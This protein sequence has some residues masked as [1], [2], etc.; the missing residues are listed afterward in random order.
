MNEHILEATIS[1]DYSGQRLDATLA[2]LFP[3]FS[4]TFLQ[5]SLK[6][7]WIQ[8]NQKNAR[9]RD[10]VVGGER[11]TFAL[12]DSVMVD[13]AQARG[14]DIPLSIVYV[15]DDLI[16]IDKPVGMVVH[17]GA[18][19]HTGTLVNALLY[20][21][22]DLQ[23]LP[24]AGII[25]RLDKETSG[26]LVVARTRVAHKKLIEQMQAREITREYS[27]LVHGKILTSGTVNAPIGR[28]PVR[29]KQMAVID[30]GRPAVTHYK[31][32]ARFEQV[33]LLRVRLETGR[34]HQIRVH[35]MH[36][37]HPVFGDP[38]YGRKRMA[39]GLKADSIAHHFN[40]QALHACHLS[41]QHPMRDEVCTWESAVPEDMAEL[42]EVFVNHSP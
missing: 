26:L 19:N 28:H 36:I 24:R 5:N 29:R 2:Q 4:R 42:L 25:H 39:K 13:N 20:R 31:I 14:E 18:G 10:T 27:C 1:E 7:G 41:L 3:S 30:D 11:V 12:D 33:T 32:E 37:Q 38:L 22:P 21:Y 9:P 15:D 17:P 6:Q 35:M 8:V 40:R 16:V 34:T 23:H